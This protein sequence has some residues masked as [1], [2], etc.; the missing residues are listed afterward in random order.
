MGSFV[1]FVGASGLRAQSPESSGLEPSSQNWDSEQQPL[2][3]P[4]VDAYESFLEQ[5]SSFLFTLLR[6]GERALPYNW[7]RVELQGVDFTSL[8]SNIT[9]YS[10]LGSYYSSAT[11]SSF[12]NS[13]FSTPD[14]PRLSLGGTRTIEYDP[15]AVSSEGF[16]SSYLSSRT[17][18]YGFGAGYSYNDDDKSGYALSV[19]RRWG[20][21]LSTQGVWSDNWDF[22]VS[23]SV[24]LGG[25][26]GG[27]LTFLAMVNPTTRALPRTA[28]LEAYD[29]AGTTL[30]NPAW[31]VMGGQEYSI[32]VRKTVE[33][34][35]AVTHDIDI[36][37]GFTLKNS[38]GVRLGES[39]YSTLMWQGTP[40]PL[41]DYYAYMP[42]YASS[43]SAAEAITEAW[44]NDV[45]ARQLDFDAMLR[46][47]MDGDE[48]ANYII[49]DRVTAP[50]F[51]RLGSELVGQDFSVG[52]SFAA[53]SEHHYKRVNSLLGGGYWLDVDTYLE[54]DSDLK[55]VTQNNVLNPSFHAQQGDVFGY[56]YR[57]NNLAG[58]LHGAYGKTLGQFSYGVAARVGLRTSQREGYFQKENFSQGDT[59]GASELDVREEWMVKAHGRWSNN[60]GLTLGVAAALSSMAPTTSQLYLSPEYRNA[61]VSG[62]TN[63]LVLGVEASLN[64]RTSLLRAN[65]SIYNYST[66]GDSRV[67]DLYDDMSNFY[68]HYAMSDIAS[69]RQGIAAS[70]EFPL[71]H[72][73]WL[74]SSAILQNNR[75]AN[76]PTATE[77]VQSTGE[78]VISGETLHYD[79]RFIGGTPQSLAAVSLSYEPRGW[80]VRL[81]G[82]YSDENYETLSP[83]RYTH[84]ILDYTSSAHSAVVYDQAKL[85]ASFSLDFFCGYTHYFER[86][87]SLGVYLSVGNILGS[88]ILRYGY[89]NYRFFSDNGTLY[90]QASR[91]SYA[92]PQNFSLSVKFNF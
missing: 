91:Y 46:T 80:F 37:E 58:E 84:R 76:N 72:N 52:V 6:Y 2:Q 55:D 82:V 45:N 30:Y 21:S 59:Y 57:I 39:A 13:L 15:L 38:L 14:A 26:K 51:A 90:P 71:V 53:Q 88:E 92:L 65:L 89:Q 77:I 83:L 86:G 75:Y 68:V 43:P 69:V 25:G 47:N 31:G 54:Q 32:G 24:M 18:A 27:K 12:D 5:S 78:E 22:S 74:R 36:L 56:N 17:Y 41:P 87:G 16:A 35:F 1:L 81:S 11:Y 85:P 66:W 79:D 40:N 34:L 49:E 9:P 44:A 48:R 60:Q 29:L 67:Q 33:P 42:S 64:Y 62:V 20:H 61:F 8:S 70:V 63:P 3:I 23:S 28:T 7:Q 10:A 19:L 73:L 4:S 50:F